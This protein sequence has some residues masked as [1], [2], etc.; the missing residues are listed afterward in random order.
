MEVTSFDQ[1]AESVLEE[2]LVVATT[3]DLLGFL[4]RKRATTTA[5]KLVDD[6]LWR[7]KLETHP[8]PSKDVDELRV[9]RRDSGV[10]AIIDA[11]IR[12]TPHGD[13]QLVRLHR[14]TDDEYANDLSD[15]LRLTKCQTLEDLCA[16]IYDNSEE[17]MWV[18]FP[19]DPELSAGDDLGRQRG[20][21][22]HTGSWTIDLSYPFH[23]AEFTNAACELEELTLLSWELEELFEQD[24]DEDDE[25]FEEIDVGHLLNCLLVCDA[26]RFR[27]QGDRA[28]RFADLELVEHGDGTGPAL[29]RFLESREILFRLGPEDVP[30][31][32]DRVL[33]TGDARQ[34]MRIASAAEDPDLA[35]TLMLRAYDKLKAE[36]IK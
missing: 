18:H 14:D 32:L 6:E 4:G 8:Q 31:L 36:R 3:S 5:L 35:Y 29:A 33:I 27:D 1:L 2:R 13:Q 24:D 25:D 12:P 34:D 30:D 20:V 28:E 15:L 10:A 26:S 22:V 9:Y 19:G 16:D 7:R 21:V 23:V 11:V 17:D